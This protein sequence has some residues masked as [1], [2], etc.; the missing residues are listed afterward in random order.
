M[1]E[2]RERGEEEEEEQGK[3][4]PERIGA[5]K[6]SGFSSQERRL[7][8]GSMGEQGGESGSRKRG[9]SPGPI[10]LPSRP[11]LRDPVTSPHLK[12]L[13]LTPLTTGSLTGLERSENQRKLGNHLKSGEEAIVI[14][15]QAPGFEFHSG[16]WASGKM[17]S[18]EHT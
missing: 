12:A 14:N 6:V 16:R 2:G 11:S 15:Q 5:R 10:G 3:A 13:T 8:W 7:F 4:T 18:Q 1:K 17:Q 9:T